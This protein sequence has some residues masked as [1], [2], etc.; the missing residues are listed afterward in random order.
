[1]AT[2]GTIGVQQFDV[3]TIIETAV[4]RC[5][6]LPGSLTTESM[7]T[8]KNNLFLGMSAL[9]NQ[10]APLWTVEKL[11][12]GLNI[13]QN[14]LV[15]PQGTIDIRNA[16]YRY[17]VLPSGGTAYSSA[18]GTADYA[19]DQD[20]TTAC[21]QTS[22]NGYISYDFGQ[23][24]VIP[25]VG[26]LPNATATLNPVYEWSNDNTTWVQYAQASTAGGSVGSFGSGSYQAGHWYWQDIPQPV[27]AQYFRIRETGGGTLNITELVFG[28]PAREITVSR[29]SA[30]DYQN[31][32]YKNQQG[33][34][35]RPLQYW[36]DRQIIPQAWLW[37]ASQYTFDSMIWWAR[38]Q[39]Q[40]VGTFTDTLE[41]PN[42]WLDAVV[43]DLAAR[44]SY[45]LQ[46]VDPNR[47]GLLEARAEKAL[48]IAWDEERDKSPT[49]I[50]PNIG[51][52]TRGS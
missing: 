8:A 30:D 33:G 47:I 10:S 36:L 50:T 23:D 21:T 51:C 13:N 19:F 5:G 42:R 27:S 12:L 31:L 22:M 38:R 34:S 14:L 26:F 4:R 28:Q 37:P 11:V 1:M 24:V 44:L 2:S 40:D 43:S 41:F 45:E 3:A 39:L 17:N 9:V 35:G 18:G 20:L 49:Y 48:G 32:P 7:Q 46:G 52:Y 25:T 29:S 15:F 6:L 16:L